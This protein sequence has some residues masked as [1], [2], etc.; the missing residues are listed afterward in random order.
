MASDDLMGLREVQQQA[1]N[2]ARE[3]L[4][5]ITD[6]TDAT[7]AKELEQQYDEAMKRADEAEKKAE[8]M[9]KL[10]DAENRISGV[11][12]SRAPEQG[13]TE[14]K[15]DEE[16]RAYRDIFKDYLS[17]GRDGLTPEEQ[18]ELRAQ[19]VGTDSA[20]GY[21]VAR[22][23]FD[24]LVVSMKDYGP[25]MDPGVVR[26][27]QTA[28]GATIDWPTM[29][30]TSSKG[31]LLGENTQDSTS[32]LS[33]GQKNLDA[34]KYTS[35]I[36][37]VSEELLQDSALNIERIVQDAMAERIGRI[38]NEHLT[39]GT[40]SGQPNG[41]VTA[42]TEGKEAAATASL[43]A[44]ELLDPFHSVDPAY[45]RM[46]MTW[47]FNDSTLKALRKLK[48]GDSNYLWQ[49]PDLRTGEPGQ[50]L[51]SP[52]YVNQDMADVGTANK[53]IIVGHMQKYILRMVREF[54]IRR[55]VERYAD[56]GQVG[57]IGFAR[58]D[59]ELIDTSAVKHLAMASS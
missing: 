43:D 4:D 38:G 5:S 33:F 41:I 20:G 10:Q 3:A 50:F 23:F 27:I 32:N 57:F 40:G 14:T 55:L 37:Q 45:R 47:M 12:E 35:G 19:A 59:G 44:D 31:S 18:R 42:S 22:E 30:D 48:D 28:T 56:Y 9:H 52:Y 13:K 49:A 16:A 54:A 39:T 34:Y 7:R 17:R 58:M 26:Q 6:D 21:T 29:D 36:F 24:E 15:A 51:G 25:M 46:G 53:P 11:T 1:I 8:R 2:D